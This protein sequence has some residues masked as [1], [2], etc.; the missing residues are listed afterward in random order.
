MARVDVFTSTLGKAMGSARAA[1]SP[2]GRRRHRSPS[3]ALAHVPLLE[4]AAAGRRGGV[5][6]GL[7]DAHGGSRRPSGKLQANARYFRAKMKAAGFTIPGGPPD[8]PR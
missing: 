4:L 8:R 7:R 5:A 2:R 3:P 6:R 1:A